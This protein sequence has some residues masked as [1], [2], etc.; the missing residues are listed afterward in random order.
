MKNTLIVGLLLLVVASLSSCG[1]K[2]TDTAR[3]AENPITTFLSSTSAVVSGIRSSGP[4]ELGLVFSPSVA[5]KLTQVG[6]KM[7]EPGTYRIIVWDNDTKAV[8][9]QKTVE[10]TAPDKL[11]LESIESLPL[12]ANKNYVISI[13]SQSGGTNKK[14]AYASKTGGGDFMPF[15]KGSVL[16]LNSTYSAVSTATF[17]SQSGSVKSEFYGFADLTFIPD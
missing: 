5:G 8:L 4:W 7:P 14:Y 12:T 6:S 2:S 15:S 1:T 11:T 17:P 9:R 16:I 3:P 13:N 10:Q